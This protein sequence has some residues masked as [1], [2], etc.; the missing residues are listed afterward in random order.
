MIQNFKKLRPLLL[1]VVLFMFTNCEK[2]DVVLMNDDTSQNTVTSRIVT[3]DELVNMPEFAG[4]FFSEFKTKSGAPN[5]KIR[6]K[7]YNFWV[8]RERIVLTQKRNY[9]SFTF[10][11]YR[12]QPSS[13]LENLFLHPYNGKYLFYLIKYD[14][15]A[16][17]L[18]NL[19]NGIPIANLLKKMDI[20]LL[21][22]LDMPDLGFPMATFGSGGGSGIVIW[23]EGQ[24]W[25]PDHVVQYDDGTAEAMTWKVCGSCTCSPPSEPP[26]PLSGY[27]YFQHID[28]RGWYGDASGGGGSGT[29][30]GGGGGGGTPSSGPGSPGY[31]TIFNPTGPANPVGPQQPGHGYP[32]IGIAGPQI[33]PDFGLVNG[34]SKK[35]IDIVNK[36]TSGNLDNCSE[37]VLEQLKELTESDIAKIITKLDMDPSVYEV[38][39]RTEAFPGG[40][41]AATTYA[42]NPATGIRKRYNYVIRLSP[43]YT[44][45]ANKLSRASILIH[46]LIHA[47]FLS[48]IDDAAYGVPNAS[49]EIATMF[50]AYVTKNFGPNSEMIHHELMANKYVDIIAR[51]IQEF[52]TGNIVP[53]NTEPNEVYKDLAWGGLQ[54]APVFNTLPLVDKERINK[55]YAAEILNYT[56]GAQVPIGEPCN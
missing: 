26:A 45:T 56:I 38:D 8:E 41:P 39:I 50:E 46:E 27:Q 20:T 33:N 13:K 14:F 35:A 29:G 22:N 31:G 40:T 3:F 48:L 36:I 17:D 52:H 53:D 37:G 43:D 6:S 16:Q 34:R 28:I 44:T 11:V 49:E 19:K 23:F 5:T 2:E 7:K 9:H 25:V 15:N 4:V 24:C 1:L 10:P 12:D 54:H 47:Y 51:A 21:K 30:P 18:L 32:I 42:I 55:R